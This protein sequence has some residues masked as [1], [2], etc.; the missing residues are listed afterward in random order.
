MLN[1]CYCGNRRVFPMLLLS[2]LS[3][4]KYTKEPVSVYLF[5]MDCTDLDGAFVPIDEDQRAVIEGVLQEKNKQSKAVL[6]R[7][8]EQYNACLRGG[9][10]E[11]NY[12]TPYT[13]LRLLMT[14]F[15][16]PD[17]ILYLDV[18]IMCCSDL[19]ELADIDV[20]AYEF[21]AVRDH[22]G[23]HF[24]G[25]DYFNAGVMYFNLE[26]VRE[27]GLMERA[28]RLVKTKKLLLNDQHALNKC[29]T[30]KLLLERRFN[31]QR[32]IR[33]DTVL[34]HFCRGI[35][36]TPFFHVY[37]IK[38]TEREK[39]HKKLKIHDFDDIY[40]AYDELAAAYGF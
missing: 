27:T 28:C 7:A 2:V 6:V 29:A 5:T 22:M 34:K 32:A 38:Q 40:A 8:D 3:V 26:K 12:Y 36:W 31:E 16:L 18:D 33:P 24:Y 10:N 14:K 19:K 15:D 20:G 39:V 35:K 1:I 30:K 9:K 13:L 37:N 21:A 17:R 11:K 4:L 23:R 25:R